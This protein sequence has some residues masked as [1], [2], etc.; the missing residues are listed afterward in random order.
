MDSE[1]IAKKLIELR[2]EKS[3]E[4]VAKALGISIS[5]I[6]MYETGARIPRDELKTKIARY[7][8]TTVE[9]IFYSEMSHSVSLPA[10]PDPP[11]TTTTGGEKRGQRKQIL[12]RFIGAGEAGQTGAALRATPKPTAHFK[13]SVVPFPHLA[14]SAKRL[15]WRDAPEAQPTHGIHYVGHL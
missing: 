8:N 4:T 9:Y 2:G 7:Y 5:A 14:H 10:G 1:K 12:P 3:R 6:G 15:D 13:R 11:A